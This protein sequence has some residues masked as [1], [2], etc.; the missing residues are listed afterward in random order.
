ML[1]SNTD[2]SYFMIGAI[3]VGA[4]IIGGAVII[5]AFF[6]GGSGAENIGEAGK[7]GEM[8]QGLFNKADAGIDGID[9]DPGTII[10]AIK[11]IF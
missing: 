3:I 6:F 5:F 4:L 1:D 10:P 11:S 2:R 7:L 9:L 8:L